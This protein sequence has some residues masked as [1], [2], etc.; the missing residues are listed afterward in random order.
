MSD[1]CAIMSDM[2]SS[3]IT[4]RI[5]DGLGARLRHRSRLKG[6]PESALVREALENYLGQ[7][8]DARAAFELADEAGLLGC[9]PRKA[10]I[11]RDLSANPRHMQDFG[12]GK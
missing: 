8:T 5:P 1:K 3:R 11:P 10:K 6:Q 7:P 2:S 9:I 12:K 4:I